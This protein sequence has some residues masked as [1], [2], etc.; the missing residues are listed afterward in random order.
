MV[1]KHEIVRAEKTRTITKD[2]ME[3]A[4]TAVNKATRNKTATREGRKKL[5][6][7]TIKQMCQLMETMDQTTWY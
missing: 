6:E 2:L 5:Q 4:I 3:N 1:I 7:K